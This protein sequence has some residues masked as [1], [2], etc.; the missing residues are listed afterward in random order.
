MALIKCSE[1]GKEFSDQANAC[2]ACGGPSP[3][4]KEEEIVEMWAA[5]CLLI[6]AAAFIV[7]PI[8]LY[9]ING[10]DDYKEAIIRATREMRKCNDTRESLSKWPFYPYYREPQYDC[11]YHRE[12][13]KQLRRS[14][15]IKYKFSIFF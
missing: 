9:T 11:S 2:P 6:I 3:K 12:K 5:G 7:V 10:P 4:A 14:N 1:C 8:A 13:V 15:W